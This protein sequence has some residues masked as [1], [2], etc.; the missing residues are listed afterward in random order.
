M[1]KE[2]YDKI[3]A[4]TYVEYPRIIYYRGFHGVIVFP[5]VE[6]F[7]TAHR[8]QLK[9]ME[10]GLPQQFPDL[11]IASI[12]ANRREKLKTRDKGY[13]VIRRAADQ[14]G[15]ALELGVED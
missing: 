13:E 14:L 6:D 3:T 10:W 11:L 4:V 15:Y 8:L 12:A 2:I 7:I 5:T 1:R 9:L